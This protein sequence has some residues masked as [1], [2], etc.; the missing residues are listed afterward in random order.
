MYY[1]EL[2]E[3]YKFSYPDN[4]SDAPCNNESKD[5]GKTKT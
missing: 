3:L 5:T 1:S 4:V 2:D